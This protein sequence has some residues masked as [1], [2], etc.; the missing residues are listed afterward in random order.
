MQ[1]QYKD[2]E[3]RKNRGKIED[4]GKCTYFS[5]VSKQFDKYHRIMYN[6]VVMFTL[7]HRQFR[8]GDALSLFGDT[9]L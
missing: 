9:V 7:V 2:K 6:I 3:L 1:R 8:A 5:E 4:L